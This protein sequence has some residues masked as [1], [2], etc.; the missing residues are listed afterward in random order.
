ME[1]KLDGLGRLVIPMEFRKVLGWSAKTSIK[2]EL[3]GDSVVLTK[4]ESRC[5]FCG[6]LDELKDVK[7]VRVCQSCID[8]IKVSDVWGA[9]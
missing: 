7:G 6:S 8:E 9:V 4:D 2:M 1:R 5:T 3:K